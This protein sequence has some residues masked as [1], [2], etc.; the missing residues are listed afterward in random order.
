MAREGL[1]T[2]LKN[3]IQDMCDETGNFR[4]MPRGALS[5]LKQDR[6]KLIEDV[7]VLLR[8]TELV[9]EET[10]KYLFTAGY[11]QQRLYE[12]EC[13]EKGIEVDIKECSSYMAR[14]SYDRKY[15]VEPIV[16]IDFLNKVVFTSESIKDIQDRVTAAYAKYGNNYAH[17][18]KNMALEIPSNVYAKEV[19]QKEFKEFIKLILPYNSAH[20]KALV[21]SIDEKMA[22]YF[23][24]LLTYNVDK[25]IDVSNRQALIDMLEI[26]EVD[27]SLSGVVSFDE[28]E[29]GS[30]Q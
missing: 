18:R 10:K 1:F 27:E 16:G 9:R 14:I 17:L 6:R 5:K 12:M 8:D 13:A 23:N 29:N 30:K 22:G 21:D 26:V 25:K 4:V 24:Y 15:R 7:I 19:D 11:S 3:L 28:V 2:A 20:M